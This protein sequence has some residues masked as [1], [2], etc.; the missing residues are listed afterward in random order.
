MEKREEA[1]SEAHVLGSW[2]CFHDIDDH[3]LLETLH[4]LIPK[5]SHPP[6]TCPPVLPRM[7]ARD[8]PAP[9]Q[10][11]NHQEVMTV[12]SRTIVHQNLPKR[13]IDD[14]TFTFF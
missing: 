14:K 10:H 9:A 11:G 1:D 4:T 6:A 12:C 3:L 5:V 7:G 13:E 8:T 2:C